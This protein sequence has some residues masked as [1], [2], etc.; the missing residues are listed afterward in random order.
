MNGFLVNLSKGELRLNMLLLY[1]PKD[2]QGLLFCNNLQNKVSTHELKI[3]VGDFNINF[4]DQN[5][6]QRLKQMMNLTN[7]SQIVTDA[8]F[9]SSGSLL[10]HVYVKAKLT[11]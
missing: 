5:D 2:M 11:G 10:D 6:S 1:H 7:Y 9:V 8:N 3:V 4:Y